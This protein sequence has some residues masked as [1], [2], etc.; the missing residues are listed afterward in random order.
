VETDIVTGVLAL[1]STIATGG[2]GAALARARKGLRPLLGRRDLKLAIL[3]TPEHAAAVMAFRA[4][5]LSSGYQHVTMTHAVTA[6]A[7]DAILVWRPA[8]ATATAT[9]D[10]LRLAS[11]MAVLVVYTLDRLDVRLDERSLLSNSPLRLRGDLATIA[12]LGSE[13]AAA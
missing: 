10:G 13:L 5:L 6:A 2:L 9:V 11:P 1:I 7:G 12:E 3:C 4:S 8:T